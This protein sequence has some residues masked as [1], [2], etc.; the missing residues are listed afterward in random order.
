MKIPFV[1][2]HKLKIPADPIGSQIGVW[3]SAA[4]VPATNSFLWVSSV[5]FFSYANWM[6]GEPN[7]V[8][9]TAQCVRI[10]PNL[11]GSWASLSC[12]QWLPFIC[13]G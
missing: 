2:K 8:G 13:E 11:L 5:R 1:N 7:N 12:D 9:N 4:Y 6:S 3:L 10:V